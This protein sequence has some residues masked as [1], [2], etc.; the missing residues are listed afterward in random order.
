MSWTVIVS[1]VR[2]GSAA[3]ASEEEAERAARELS[4]AVDEDT[5]IAIGD[6]EA[7][8]TRLIKIGNA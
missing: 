7:N 4:E 2:G 6:Q 1:G 3:Y 8:T 5:W